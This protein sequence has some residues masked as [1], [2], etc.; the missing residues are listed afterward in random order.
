[1]KSIDSTSRRAVI[2]S[3]VFGLI[4]A[5]IPNIGFAKE[6]LETE[7][8]AKPINKPGSKYPSIE[9]EIVAIVV[10]S[11]H[12]NLDKVKELVTPRPELARACW[13][14]AFG[15]FETA[16]GAASHTGRKDIASFLMSMGAR[17]DIFTYAMF[18]AYDVVKNMIEATPGIQSIAG[19]H[20]ISLLRHAKTGLNSE[21]L[22]PKNKDDSKKLIEYLEELGNAD[23]NE[24]F[25]AY[26]ESE[27]Q[28]YLGD[29]KYGEG[30]DDGFSIK[31][32]MRKMLSLGRLGS[33][34]GG[35]YKRG[36]NRYIYNGVPSVEV[37]F[38][39]ING[40]IISLTV[41]E[42]GLSLTAKKI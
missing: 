34:G 3:S 15:D 22:T 19:P 1:M 20:G 40:Q 6:F 7:T 30:P 35:L 21:N 32:N 5:S 14:W 11:S 31:M 16:L 27:S 9:D 41:Q 42:P 29:Y 10:G 2:K 24:K 37:S 8:P 13:D 38:S 26:T 17:P 25:V 28:I 12:A 23:G 33:F 4:T 36:D 39:V 18:G